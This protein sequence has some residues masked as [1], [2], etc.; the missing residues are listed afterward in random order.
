MNILTFTQ[1]RTG[2]KVC[3]E[4]RVE[5]II[6]ELEKLPGVYCY[7]YPIKTI[8]NDH[9]NEDFYTCE[10][11]VKK[12]GRKTNWKTVKEVADKAS[13]TYNKY[14]FIKAEF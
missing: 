9:I 2:L 8:V 14:K 5:H 7:A 13:S 6:K 1:S 12:I 10:I 11:H 4:Y 3:L